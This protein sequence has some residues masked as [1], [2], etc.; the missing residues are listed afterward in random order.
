MPSKFRA[1]KLA[2]DSLNI[3]VRRET[4]VTLFTDAHYMGDGI[5]NVTAADV[6]MSGSLA[7]RQSNLDT[8]YEMWRA[9]EG[10]EFPVF[11]NIVSPSGNI[12]MSKS[13]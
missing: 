7:E 11:V 9:A 1:F 8:L 4:G 2:F 13:G 6:W 12:V 3:E 5:V 10:S